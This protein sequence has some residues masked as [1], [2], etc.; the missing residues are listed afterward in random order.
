M[1]RHP[2]ISARLVLLGPPAAINATLYEKLNF[3]VIRDIAPVA[4]IARAPQHSGSE[5][6]GSG[7][8]GSR[9]H[10][11]C[12]G[13]SWKAQLCV[14]WNWGFAPRVRRFKMMAGVN[15]VHV[16]YRGAVAAITDMFSGQVF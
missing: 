1:K 14:G 5:P 6:V 13:Q 3:N 15:L 11:L 16:P 10:C 12:Q 8:D 9:V 4:S 7:Q 2:V